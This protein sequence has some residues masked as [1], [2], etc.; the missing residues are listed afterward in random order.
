MLST[1]KGTSA[2]A[3]ASTVDTPICAPT[4]V[5]KGN[6]RRLSCCFEECSASTKENM[7]KWKTVSK[8]VN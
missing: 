5:E 2:Y 8:Q 7:R 6:C 3:V 1:N 4:S